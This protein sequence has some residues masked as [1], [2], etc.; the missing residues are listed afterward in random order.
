M[1]TDP[2]AYDKL[3][4]KYHPDMWAQVIHYLIEF[5]EKHDALVD[6]EW[7]KCHVVSSQ[8]FNDATSKLMFD[9]NDDQ[10]A[11]FAEN[12]LNTLLGEYINDN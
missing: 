12:V 3:V 8:V 10:S 6:F 7:A 5:M 2:T 4:E 9:R 1:D 11:D